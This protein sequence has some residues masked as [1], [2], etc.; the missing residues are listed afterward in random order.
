MTKVII[1]DNSKDAC[2]IYEDT[3]TCAGYN[4]QAICEEEKALETIKK[5]HPDL[6]LLDM[7]MPKI[8]GM[9]LLDRILSD[10]DNKKTRVVILTN[11][12]DSKIATE[13]IGHGARDYLIKTEVGMSE[14]LKRIDRA[15]ST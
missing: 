9:H 7:L 12:T 13:A 10:K 11:L 2:R 6:V 14:L 3:L 1:V 8:S 5:E 15:L 4:V